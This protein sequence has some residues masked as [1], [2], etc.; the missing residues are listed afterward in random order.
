MPK[1]ILIIPGDG[2]INFT[3]ATSGTIS[4]QVGATG[5]VAFIGATGA[6]LSLVDAQ[7]G[8]VG[9]GKTGPNYTLDVDGEI[10]V[11]GRV[12]LGTATTDPTIND[13]LVRDPATGLIKSR[14]ASS[15]AQEV[16]VQG[17]GTS[18]SYRC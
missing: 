11:A 8:R 4:L 17:S 14:S 16:I 15:L 7:G 2:R 9:I 6:L 1:D 3:G 5:D 18:S 12:Y 10:G 13:V